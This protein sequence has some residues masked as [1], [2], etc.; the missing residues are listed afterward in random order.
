MCTDWIKIYYEKHHVKPEKLE[1]TFSG[2][3]LYTV[4]LDICEIGL[5]STCRDLDSRDIEREWLDLE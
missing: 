3:R 5:L 4:I 1:M 2:V